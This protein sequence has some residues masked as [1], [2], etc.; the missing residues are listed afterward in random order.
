[1]DD[2]ERVSDTEEG[3]ALRGVFARSCHAMIIS[4]DLLG[5]VIAWHEIMKT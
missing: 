4:I 2:L 5:E 1:M 3:P